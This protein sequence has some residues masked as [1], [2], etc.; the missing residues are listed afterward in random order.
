MNNIF[1]EL[2][3][4]EISVRTRN[5]RKSICLLD[6]L[7]DNELDIL[8]NGC[9]SIAMYHRQAMNEYNR[10]K[11]KLSALTLEH[12]DV[13]TTSVQIVKSRMKEV[14]VLLNPI[15]QE[16]VYTRV[17]LPKTPRFISDEY[18]IK[19]IK[20][21]VQPYLGIQREILRL[22]KSHLKAFSKEYV[23]GTVVKYGKRKIPGQ[24]TLFAP[25][26]SPVLP[27]KAESTKLVELVAA[28]SEAKVFG[29]EVTRKEL[30]KYFSSVFDVSMEH[31]EKS[32]SQMKYRKS[33][34]ARFLDDMRDRFVNLME[35]GL[36]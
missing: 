18:Q 7:D 9:D 22:T 28:L 34:P 19:V 4:A 2:S 26:L 1:D 14:S 10:F 29:E 3:K 11:E 16:L 20:N 21:R 30:W 15:D 31:A 35:K 17:V 8:F 13:I 25:S 12:L 23:P 5:S 24:H 33:Q 32:L 6:L 36:D 27:W